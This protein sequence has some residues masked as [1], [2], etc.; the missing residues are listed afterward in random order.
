MVMCLLNSL[1]LPADTNYAGEE[2][3]GSLPG[4]S[5]GFVINDKDTESHEY[6]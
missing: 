2:S 6:K 4:I 3:I 5:Q 1:E